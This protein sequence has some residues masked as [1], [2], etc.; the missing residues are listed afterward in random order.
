MFNDEE[1]YEICKYFDDINIRYFNI[2]TV[3]EMRE[4]HQLLTNGDKEAYIIVII[5]I[6][7]TK[8]SKTI[9]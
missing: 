8:L 5:N 3:D 2:P 9:L 4:V 1:K 7:Q 6:T